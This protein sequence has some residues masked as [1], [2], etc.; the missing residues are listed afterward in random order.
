VNGVA[1]CDSMAAVVELASAGWRSSDGESAVVGEMAVMKL[2]LLP[3]LTVIHA[4]VPSGTAGIAFMDIGMTRGVPV[5]KSVPMVICPVLVGSVGIARGVGYTGA[6]A[7]LVVVS[8]SLLVG[9]TGKM[10]SKDQVVLTEAK[11]VEMT[12]CGD[13]DTVASAV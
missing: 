5:A 12:E 1:G 13:V 8:L 7:M 3:P 6:V 10:P 4:V 9:S 2:R 11:A